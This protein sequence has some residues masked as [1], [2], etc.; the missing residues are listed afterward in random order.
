MNYSLFSEEK[1][2]F[3]TSPIFFGDGRNIQR[4]E[5]PK[6]PFFQKLAETMWKMH[7]VKNEFDLSKDKSDYD[8]LSD[9]EKH[10]FDSNIKSQ[11]V[12]DSIQGRGPFQTFG[13]ICTNPE[14]ESCLSKIDTFEILHSES[15]TEI[16]RN[17]FTKPDI[18][19]DGIMDNEVIMKRTRTMVKYYDTFYADVIEYQSMDIKGIT[20]SEEFMTQIKTNLY[21]ALI[22]LNILEGI[23]FYVSFAC[24]FA[25]AENQKMEG[26]AKTIKKIS[27]DEAQHLAFSQKLISI[28][29]KDEQEGFADIAQ[30]LEDEVYAM[31]HEACEEENEWI[32]YLFKDGSIIGLNATLL[33]QYMKHITNQ[34]LQSIGY[35]HIY[36]KTENPLSWMNHWLSSKSVEVA[37]QE[38]EISTYLIGALDKTVSDDFLSS[39][40]DI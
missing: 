24:T 37:P 17:I 23:R 19:F 33:K 3:K 15:Y 11:I 10:I 26:N 13:Q 21:K 40:K 18:I 20:P 39:L 6:Y 35:K 27:E 36:E 4:Y 16:L 5:N 9:H 2:D 30:S 22:N 8:N 32:D 25:F 38:T 28:L 12:N 1:T 14:V 29:K 31:Y 7:W 34:R